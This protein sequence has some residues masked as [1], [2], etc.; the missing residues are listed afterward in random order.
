MGTWEIRNAHY[1]N[2]DN[3]QKTQINTLEKGEKRMRPFLHKESEK[4]EQAVQNGVNLYIVFYFS[5]K[6]NF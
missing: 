6:E 1:G 3:E 4:I 5:F 2:T